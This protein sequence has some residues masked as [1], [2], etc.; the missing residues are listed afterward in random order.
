MKKP[1]IRKEDILGREPKHITYVP[2]QNGGAHDLL[3][4]K[5][6][7][8]L[9]D[10][11]KVPH[12]SYHRDYKRPFWITQKGRQTHQEKREYEYNKYLHKY[13]TTQIDLPKAAAR[14][15]GDFGRGLNP[16]LKYLGR[17]PYLYGTDVT[18][19]CLLKNDYRRRWSGYNTPNTVAA[20]DTEI[21]IFSDGE[22]IICQ[23]LTC[24]NKAILVYLRSWIKDIP[25][26][27]TATHECAKQYLSQYLSERHIDL[28]VQIVD[29]SAEIVQLIFQRAHEWA[30]DFVTFWNI[31][32]DMTW[33]LQDLERGNVDP[34]EVFSDPDIPAPYRMFNYDRSPSMRT[35]ASGKTVS[36]NIED[37]WNWVTHPA[38][39]Q[40]ID[41]LPV[42]RTLRIA[43]G[44]ESSYA[45]DFILNK[46][47]PGHSKMKLEGLDHL[48]GRRWHEVMQTEHKIEYGVYNLCDSILLELLDEKTRDL[49]NS[50]TTASQN[51]EYRHFNSNPKKLCD[52]LH[53]WHRERGEVIASSSDDP[54]IEL[55]KHV[56]GHNGWIVTLPSFMAA[57]HGITCVKEIPTYRT[58]VFGH[59]ADLDL[60]SAYPSITQFLNV[61]RET[62]WMEFSQMKGISEHRRR[63]V[64]VNLTGG[65][66][67]ATEICEKILGGAPLDRLLQEFQT[68]IGETPDDTLG[69]VEGVQYHSVIT[70]L[71]EEM[72][73]D[74]I[75]SD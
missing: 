35:T 24:K 48:G 62:C 60:V 33:M 42:Y 32:S 14:A 21:D 47:L 20:S 57:P 36:I 68:E 67:N 34:A 22:E 74:T 54:E 66:V 25:D 23:S 18:S 43:D 61:G 65:H 10:G 59:V 50:I 8:H 39:F 41:S 52:A 71:D 58:L 56:I 51:S 17:N 12:L 27:I 70:D 16:P 2:E 45:L 19:A 73:D 30:P 44:K 15:L 9:K 3:V 46:Q 63:E 1:N 72:L 64:G 4:A 37:R 40:I 29:T 11:R 7:L 69:E 5:E 6:I 75:L 38:S 28:E 26:P 49:S 31:D 53:F 13:T 55:D